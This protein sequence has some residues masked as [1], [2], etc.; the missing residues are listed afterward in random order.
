MKKQF[1]T[2]VILFTFEFICYSQTIKS[3]ACNRAVSNKSYEKKLIKEVCI[4]N[5]YQISLILTETRNIDMDG[6]GV[7]DFVFNWSKPQKIDGDTTFTT[8]YKK[9]KD[10]SFTFL[11]TFKNLY[12]IYF[13]N[14]NVS[15]YINANKEI[16]KFYND[17]VGQQP[18]FKAIDFVGKAGVIS[19]N[20][21]DIE[22]GLGFLV[23]YKYNSKLK[24]WFLFSQQKWE[25]KTTDGQYNG[26]YEYT[27]L[28][29]P[30]NPENINKFSFQKYVCPDSE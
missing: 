15:T 16:E 22:T 13:K 6:D 11:K 12:P 26:I 28:K 2:M 3:P 7:G 9:N 29:L 23:K 27:D 25:E 24:D 18:L 17:C 5:G 4:P 10:N 30:K 8:V 1:L 20:F 21:N 14:Y 19:I